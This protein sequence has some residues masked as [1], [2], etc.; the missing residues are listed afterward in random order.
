[1][2]NIKILSVVMVVIMLAV[3]MTSCLNNGGSDDVKVNCTISVV[4]GDTYILDEY[5]YEAVGEG[6]TPPS[7]LNAVE[8]I[9][10]FNDIAYVAD[11]TGF[12]SIS[13]VDGTVYENGAD[14]YFWLCT[15][16]GKEMKGRANSVEVAEG[17][18]IVYTYT[19]VEAE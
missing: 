7:V 13:D 18:V 5:P 1:M 14:N 11:D 12:E 17:D 10:L 3:S 2:K 16:N 9:L 15:I 19:L 6:D 4:A 8:G